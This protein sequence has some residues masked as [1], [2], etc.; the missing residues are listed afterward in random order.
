[1]IGTLKHLIKHSAIYGMGG[2]LNKLIGFVLLPI[3]TRYLTPTDYGILSLLG[4]SSSIAVIIAR[5]GLGSAMFREVIYHGSDERMVESTTLYFLLGESALCF[6]ILFIWS[7]QVSNLVF[8]TPE[9]THL[10]RLVF[11]TG[12]LNTFEV[13]VMAKLRLRAQSAFYSFLSVAGFLIGITL[14]LYFIVVLHRGVEGLVAAGLISAALFGAFYLLLLLKDLQPIFSLQILRRML[15]FGVPLVPVGLSSLLLTMA[16][17]FFLQHFTTTAEVGLYSLGYNI[18]MV[19]NLAGQAFQLAWPPYRFALAKQPD[20]ERQFAK[21]L[22][23]FMIAFGFMGVAL[24]VFA[25]EVLVLMTTPKFYSA[26]AVVP[27]IALSYIF[28]GARYITNIGLAVQNKMIYVPPIIIG[29]ALLNLGLNY[30]LIPPYGM[31]G[32]AWA[33]VISYFTMVVV[34]TVVN[35][36]FWY[37]HYEYHRM[38]KIALV[39]VV[40]YGTNLLIQTSNLWLNIGLKLVL[41]TSYPFLL[42]VFRFYEKEELTMVKGFFRSGWHTMRAWR[43]SS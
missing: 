29:S 33:T 25:R 30:L 15:A 4:V 37:I 8:G 28:S 7:P 17:R 36:H 20:A 32:A 18:G 10:V 24:S 2:V 14:N 34:T 16:D 22:S 19:M 35:Q 41:L 23:Y 9:Y 43:V 40:I 3:Y 13:V 1:M 11:L 6:G 5:L 42:Y 38:V 26:Y 31:M 21:I 39:W 12:F 27:L